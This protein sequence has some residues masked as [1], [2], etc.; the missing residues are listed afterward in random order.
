M[1]VPSFVV[2]QH[3]QLGRVST[4]LI[5]SLV[6]DTSYP[7]IWYGHDGLGVNVK[8]SDNFVRSVR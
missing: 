5:R 2:P 4:I 7:E 8:Y 3:K 6:K 1:T